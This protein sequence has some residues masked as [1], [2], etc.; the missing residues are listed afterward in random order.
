M[1]M[2]A[3][4][5]VTHATQ[6]ARV[7]GMTLQ[8]G[9][10]LNQILTE[11]LQEYDL[12]IALHTQT[13]N[14]NA[15]GANNGTGPYSLPDDYMR[16]ASRGATYTINNIPYVLVQISL[17]QFDALIN[18]TGLSSYPYNFTTDVSTTPPVFFVYPPPQLSID[19]QMRYYGTLPEI[20]SP[21]TSA[22]VPWFTNQNYLVNRLTGELMRIAGDQRADA[23]LG[24]GPSGCVGI[25]R[26]WLN[27]QGDREDAA[28][29]MQ[30]DRRYFG[31]GRYGFP[32]SRITGGLP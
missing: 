32:P 16:M 13:I 28:N 1:P 27:L 2:T 17:V 30:L 31:P 21:E 26:R 24:D 6:I 11:L 29:V 12:A 3:S 25:L 14:V 5:I 4:Q 15:S 23:I 22:V 9:R 18:Q 7:P 20:A 10:I 19:I 8:A